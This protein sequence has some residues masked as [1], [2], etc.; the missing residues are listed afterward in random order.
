MPVMGQRA[1]DQYAQHR[2]Q[3]PV[4]AAQ[5]LGVGPA[6]ASPNDVLHQQ[7]GPQHPV[8]RQRHHAR[9]HAEEVMAEHGCRQQ[10]YQTAGQQA[11]AQKD[12]RA[13]Y[14]QGSGGEGDDHPVVHVVKIGYAGIARKAVA[15][16]PRA[17]RGRSP[18]LAGSRCLFSTPCFLSPPGRAESRAAGPRS[19][20]WFSSPNSGNVLGIA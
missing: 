16:S 18:R 3:R 10:H 5:R 11:A 14:Q 9:R 15:L 4:V 17:A 13:P 12:H 2:Q 1:D 8:E 7:H 20:Q 6:Q 19:R